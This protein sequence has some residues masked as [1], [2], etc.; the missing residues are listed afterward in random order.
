MNEH[1]LHAWSKR[2]GA[3]AS[4]IPTA[5]MLW[6]FDSE[7]IVAAD[8]ASLASWPD[9]SPNNVDMQSPG[10]NGGTQFTFRDNGTD[11]INGHPVVETVDGDQADIPFPNI[12]P[13]INDASF[14]HYWVGRYNPATQPGHAILL[15]TF[16]TP[17]TAD[18]IR[19]YVAADLDGTDQ[20]GFE[21]EV[22]PGSAVDV[23]IAAAV[24]GVQLL[25]YVFDKTAGNAKV[26]RNG[27]QIGSTST[28]VGGTGAGN[29]FDW[30]NDFIEF[31]AANGGTNTVVGDHARL[32]GYSVAH[33]DT[34]REAIETE[35]M[36]DYG[37]S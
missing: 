14:T 24:S 25:T 18:V 26:Y 5:N 7:N 29:G 11:N 19:L 35:L 33:D 3:V 21:H 9:A 17:G 22:P 6:H 31:F 15:Y 2:E 32:I 36:A 27:A 1:L 10:T 13:A 20:V 23:D 30:G 34:T 28:D 4:A 8:G 37:I 16:I 12:S